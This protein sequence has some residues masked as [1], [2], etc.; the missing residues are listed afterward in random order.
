[1]HTLFSFSRVGARHRKFVDFFHFSRSFCHDAECF[2]F[3][4]LAT[5]IFVSSCKRVTNDYVLLPQRTRCRREEKCVAEHVLP[6][7]HHTCDSFR[8]LG[9]NCS[10]FCTI[11]CWAKW[12]LIFSSRYRRRFFRSSANT[13]LGANALLQINWLIIWANIY[14]DKNQKSIY[15]DKYTRRAQW[16]RFRFHSIDRFALSGGFSSISF[17]LSDPFK[18]LR[19]KGCMHAI[20]P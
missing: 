5:E 14:D 19:L 9:T 18:W 4:F 17:P 16:Q 7:S 11:C 13:V 10:V 2:D 8:M 1:M 15:F 20:N 3:L 12:R 6:E